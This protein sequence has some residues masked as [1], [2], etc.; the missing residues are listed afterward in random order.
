MAVIRADLDLCQ[1]YA[2]CVLAADDVFDIDDD[3]SVVLLRTDVPGRTAPASRRR[4]AAARS[5]R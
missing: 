3:G 2:N 5:R 4:P 1:G